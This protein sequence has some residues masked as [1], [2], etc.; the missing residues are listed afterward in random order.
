VFTVPAGGICLTSEIISKEQL[1]ARPHY[2]D[3]TAPGGLDY[4]LSCVLEN[5]P[6]YFSNISYMRSE[7]FSASHKCILETLVPHLQTALQLSQRIALAD[8]GRRG[9]L[10]SFDRVRQPVVLL[11]RS[12]YAIHCN[13]HA[14]R[15]LKSVGD[16]EIKFGRFLFENVTTQ[17]EF[18]RA[19]RVAAASIGSDIPA[20]PYRIRVTRRSGGSPYALVVIPVHDSTQRALMPDG[21]AC[22]ILLHD[23]DHTEELPLERLAWLYRLTP[24]EIRICESLYREGS[25]DSAAE[26]LHLTRNTVRSHLKSIY[27]KFGVAT[28]GQLMQRLA[29]SATLARGNIADRFGAS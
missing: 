5:G 8:A 3:V 27:G 29:N 23:L 1:T 19:V 9:T 22:M 16:L 6:D 28:Q 13:E 20:A 18:E 7:D 25:I 4:S 24:A 17:A 14:D 26:N 2:K 11:D 10:T 15:L 12:G 21:A